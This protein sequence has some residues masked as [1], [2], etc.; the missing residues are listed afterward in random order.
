MDCTLE[1]YFKVVGS[2]LFDEEE[3]YMRVRVDIDYA[4]EV[5]FQSFLARQVR[6]AADTC[7]VPEENVTMIPRHQYTVESGTAE[8]IT[9]NDSMEMEWRRMR[10][11][12]RER[13]G[14]EEC[15]ASAKSVEKS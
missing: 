13:R 10:E 12:A 11:I 6:W 8:V 3:G 1:T 9:F 4:E 14:K 5:D 15:T 7:S 2:T